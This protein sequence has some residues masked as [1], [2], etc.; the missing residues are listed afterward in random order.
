MGGKRQTDVSRDTIGLVLLVSSGGLTGCVSNV[1][2]DPVA[3][4]KPHQRFYDT[5]AKQEVT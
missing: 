4:M 5:E 3:R 1:A 2:T